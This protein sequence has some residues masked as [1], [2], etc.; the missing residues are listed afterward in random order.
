[1][2]AEIAFHSMKLE[3]MAAIH[4]QRMLR[5]WVRNTVEQKAAE[6]DAPRDATG[7]TAAQ[8][9]SLRQARAEHRAQP[10]HV[11]IVGWQ[12]NFGRLLRAFDARLP[13]GSHIFLLSEKEVWWRRRDL[14][15]EG[16]AEDGTA[17]S[18]G[19]FFGTKPTAGRKQSFGPQEQMDYDGGEGGGD[20][21]GGDDGGGDADADAD[22]DGEVE[23]EAGESEEEEECLG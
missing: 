5:G 13:R 22:A 10:R 23:G 12:R 17:T 9:E 4:V 20:A 1:M 6:S 16:L 15:T 11:A 7:L 21:D 14:A 2:S 19:E 3:L 18:A 8:K